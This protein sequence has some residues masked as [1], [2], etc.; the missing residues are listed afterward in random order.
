MTWSSIEKIYRSFSSFQ[1]LYVH[2]DTINGLGVGARRGSP[3][4][5]HPGGGHWTEELGREGVGRW[6]SEWFEGPMRCARM[7]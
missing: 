2:L 3:E 5:L 1:R 6:S 7:R 4:D